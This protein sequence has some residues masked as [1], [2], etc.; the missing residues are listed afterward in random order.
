MD[1]RAKLNS[2]IEEIANLKVVIKQRIDL[3]E[4][5]KKGVPLVSEGDYF[6]IL[7]T[8]VGLDEAYFSLKY[9]LEVFNNVS[10]YIEF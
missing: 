2:L 7:T 10:D 5:A 8:I 1:V 9:A 6:L 4:S 3:D